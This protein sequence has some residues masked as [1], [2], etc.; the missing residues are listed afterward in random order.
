MT[1]SGL[2]LDLR[3]LP[4]KKTQRLWS[5]LR[6]VWVGNSRVPASQNTVEKGHRLQRA[7]P[8]GSGVLQPMRRGSTRRGQSRR[9][10]TQAWGRGFHPCVSIITPK[11]RDKVLLTGGC[12]TIFHKLQVTAYLRIMKFVQ[13]AT[14]GIEEKEVIKHKRK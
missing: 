3:V 10:E 6:A 8:G 13:W 5:A 11:Q 12:I 14:S 4:S 2:P 7:L 1:G 9:S